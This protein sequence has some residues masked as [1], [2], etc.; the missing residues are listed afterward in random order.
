[1][2]KRK[3][4]TFF[5]KKMIHLT[6]FLDKNFL[7]NNKRIILVYL[8]ILIPSILL[9]QHYF[10]LLFSLS[11]IIFFII[12]ILFVNKI[13]T[14]SYD[15][16]SYIIIVTSIIIYLFIISFIA[17]AYTGRMDRDEMLSAT[18]IKILNGESP[19]SA[20]WY[21]DHSTKK[22]EKI[23]AV[24]RVD[25]MPFTI[26]FSIPFFLIGNVAYQDLIGYIL[27]ALVL[28]L[29]YK[30]KKTMLCSIILLS[31]SPLIIFE[32]MGLN[33][34]LIGL[35]LFILAVYLMFRHKDVLLSIILALAFLTRP[36]LWIPAG[37][38]MGKLLKTRTIKQIFLV[39]LIFLITI[40]I[41][42]IPFLL[43]DANGLITNVLK[44]GANKA[45]TEINPLVKYIFPE[46]NRML[47]ISI[48]LLIV[49]VLIG[50]FLGK[51]RSDI[52]LFTSLILVVFFS[53][54]AFIR[55]GIDYSHLIWIVTPAFF[56]FSINNKKRLN[57]VEKRYVQ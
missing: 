24:N 9:I 38:I 51:R 7:I 40:S 27:L 45:Q 50:Y 18:S 13:K 35:S 30:N 8:L 34:L 4:A 57:K 33:D 16:L 6:R 19:Y 28:M 32:F 49:S 48:P 54:L 12:I 15:K 10:N 26:L 39:G 22:G 44:G 2:T 29:I 56:A 25:V 47:W 23:Y 52:Y 46:T 37:I 11:Y 53:V 14:N 55:L 17:P 36:V 42:I 31:T 21:L 5:M 43:V 41:F 3:I 1:M 20:T